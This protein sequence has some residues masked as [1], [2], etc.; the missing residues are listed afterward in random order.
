MKLGDEYVYNKIFPDDD[1]SSYPSH[2]SH[3]SSS[4]SATDRDPL[5]RKSPIPDTLHPT[6]YNPFSEKYQPF[7]KRDLFINDSDHRI[8]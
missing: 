6:K 2:A 8:S 5:L 1:Y 3:G 7:F 4:I